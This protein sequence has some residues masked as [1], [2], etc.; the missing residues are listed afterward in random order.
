MQ[1][2]IGTGR[3]DDA[4]KVFELNKGNIS[5][6]LFEL[7]TSQTHLYLFLSAAYAGKKE[8]DKSIKYLKKELSITKVWKTWLL[9]S[10]DPDILW[11]RA[12]GKGDMLYSLFLIVFD[13][14]DQFNEF[15]KAGRYG[16]IE[17][18][19]ENSVGRYKDLPVFND[20]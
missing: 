6:D 20:E 11:K 1:A 14:G 3:Y 9:G 16:E 13:L 19:I 2:Y 15:K 5:P 8:L 4:I 17:R 10:H 12:M 18:L 7:K